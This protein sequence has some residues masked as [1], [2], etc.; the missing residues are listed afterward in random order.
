MT[1]MNRLLWSVGSLA[2]IAAL[3]C[4]GGDGSASGG[5]SGTSGG[6]KGGGTGTSG[7]GAG[8]TGG[9]TGATGG[10]TG[11]TGGGTGSTGGGT[12]GS[13]GGSAQTLCEKYGGADTIKTVVTTK[14]VPEFAGDCRIQRH[15]TTLPGTQLTHVVECLTTQVQEL[16]GCA[17]K[18][19]AGS[20]DTA[21][22]A[23]R[24]MK[25]AHANLGLT[26]GDFNALIEDTVAGLQKAGVAAADINAAAPALLGMRSDIVSSNRMSDSCQSRALQSDGGFCASQT[27]GGSACVHA[28]DR[29]DGPAVV[30]TV[31]RTNLVSTLAGDCR[32]SKH[33]TDLPAAGLNHVKDCLSTQVKEIF[34]CGGFVYAGSKDSQGVVCRD[35]VS[36]HQ[37]LKISDGDFNALIEDVVSTLQ[38][39]NVP[40]DIIGAAAP[41]LLGVRSAAV[42]TDGG[43]CNTKPLS[44]CAAADAGTC[45]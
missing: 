13:G 42:T 32:I 1:R 27:D 8:S 28:C 45:Q 35:M 24:D 11:S 41:T 2:L 5:G 29:V 17:G 12:G 23:C 18:V 40:G 37:A 19:Y 10:G 38:A 16:F 26:A 6:G 20:K 15:F 4:S 34:G 30:D 22:V 3:G 36:A 44:A 39:A 31:V 43:V 21:G 7:G 14:V 9:G 33:F 25:T